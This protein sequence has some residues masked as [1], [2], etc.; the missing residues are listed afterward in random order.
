MGSIFSEKNKNNKN[1]I[2][3]TNNYEDFK[4]MEEL[5][6]EK[7]VGI[8]I[9]RMKAYSCN[10]K[11]NELNEKREYFWNIKTN[12][13]SPNW[14]TWKIIHRAILYDEIRAEMLLE[15]YNIKPVNGCINYLID[16]NGNEY[17]IPN[18]C[19]NDPYFEKVIN[20]NNNIN[21]GNINLRFY[22]VNLNFILDVNNEFKGIELKNKIKNEIIGDRNKGLR[23]FENGIEIKDDDFLYQHNLNNEKPIWILLN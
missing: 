7:Y 2:I 8:G 17:K 16:K 22:G 10:L 4:D 18:Y 20:E 12:I 6:E 1:N 13:Y 5:S 3:I 9:K 21:K 19:I 15:E 14:I 11:I 23:L